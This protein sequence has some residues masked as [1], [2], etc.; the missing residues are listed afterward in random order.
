M[1]TQNFIDIVWGRIISNQTTEHML[2]SVYSIIS[3]TILTVYSI[4][5]RSAYHRRIEGV[6][7]GI[8]L[9]HLSVSVPLYSNQNEYRMLTNA[10]LAARRLYNIWRR[11][12]KYRWLVFSVNIS[13]SAHS[14]WLR[15]WS[16]NYHEILHYACDHKVRRVVRINEYNCSSKRNLIFQIWPY[17]C[18][19]TV[20]LKFNLFY[21]S[22]RGLAWR[23]DIDILATLSIRGNL[24][25]LISVSLTG[26]DKYTLWVAIIIRLL[27]ISS[28]YSI[29]QQHIVMAARRTN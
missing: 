24:A 25:C 23:R 17:R 13:N 28:K 10:R 9:M 29:Y 27:Q 16:I 8:E 22:I 14:S 26:G 5:N 11:R 12:Y 21:V 4:S 7:A 19:R 15:A 1:P 3:V 20:I 18:Y 6:K 2:T